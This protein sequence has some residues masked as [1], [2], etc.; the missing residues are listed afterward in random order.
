M[1]VQLK[2]K[3][4]G[5]E[6][7]ENWKQKSEM[8]SQPAHKVLLPVQNAVSNALL[9]PDS[10]V[11]SLLLL[12][13]MLFFFFTT[14]WNSKNFVCSKSLLYYSDN[15]N[16]LKFIC[17]RAY[18]RK[19]WLLDLYCIFPFIFRFLSLLLSQPYVVSTQHI[20]S[21]IRKDPDPYINLK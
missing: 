19:P 5:K 13:L 16:D 10:P 18:C 6:H 7:A 20:T 17:P 8:M 11:S 4:L 1:R 3:R 14:H 9:G 15:T 21:L 2:R 12:A